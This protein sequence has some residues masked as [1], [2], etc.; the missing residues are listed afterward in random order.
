MRTDTAT[1]TLFQDD[2]D[3]KRWLAERGGPRDRESAELAAPA[4]FLIAARTLTRAD[5]LVAAWSALHDHSEFRRAGTGRHRVGGWDVDSSRLLFRQIVLRPLALR[6]LMAGLAGAAG[7]LLGLG[8]PQTLL[9]MCAVLSVRWRARYYVVLTVVAAAVALPTWWFPPL[10]VMTF[11]YVHAAADLLWNVTGTAWWARGPVF[12]FLPFADRLLLWTR[13]RWALFT[14]AVDLATSGQADAAEPFLARCERVPRHCRPVLGM[15]RAMHSLHRGDL[16]QALSRAGA[17]VEAARNSPAGVRGWCRAHLSHVL[18][19]GG[20]LDEAMAVRDEALLLLKGRRCRRY[21]RELLLARLSDDLPFEPVASSLHR[22]HRL[23]RVALRASDPNLLRQTEIWIVQLMLR[24]G[25]RAGAAWIL[26]GLLAGDDARTPWH[27]TPDQAANERLLRASVLVE[28]ESTRDSA[29]R[30]ALAALAIVDAGRRPLAAVAARLLLARAD[31]FDGRPGPALAQAAHALAAVHDARYLIPSARGRKQ[32]E[33]VQLNAYATV[34]RLA[35][36][37]GDA[38]LLAEVVETV[39][40]EVL[41]DR[42]D[43]TELEAHLALDAMTATAAPAGTPDGDGGTAVDTAAE[44]ADDGPSARGRTRSA[45]PGLDPVRRPPPVR[46]A[47]RRRLPTG[48]GRSGVIDLDVELCALGGRC[49][50]WSAAVVLDRYYWVV[51][52]PDGRWTHGSADIAQQS[53]AALAD[54]A[55]RQALPLP[56]PGEDAAAAAARADRGPLS[57]G[58]GPDGGKERA[59]LGSVAEAF[60]PAPLAAGLRATP[61]D[62]VPSLVVSLPAALAHLPVPALPLEPG[63]DRRV[64]DVARV[65]HVPAWS[66]VNQRL[67]R[68]P[69]QA[70]QPY[71]LRLAVMAPD[72]DPV[73]AARLKSPPFARRSLGGPLPKERLSQVLHLLDDDRHWLLYLAGHVTTEWNPT[74]GGLRLGPEGDGYGHLSIAEMLAAADSGPHANLFPVPE[75]VLAVGCGSLGLE[76]EPETGGARTPT[77]EW[78]GFGS[79]LMF[80]GADHVI[81]T[82]YPV[83]PVGQLNDIAHSL[84]ERLVAGDSPADALRDVQLAEL[85]RWRGTGEGR[86]F[87]WQ[88]FVYAGV[89]I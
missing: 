47:G 59:L 61:P 28:D 2:D 40:G 71:D 29:R 52:D 62:E 80:A 36:R 53:P 13:G 32:W 42:I 34:L 30:D 84:A 10:A 83:Y 46:V 7:S 65:L 35:E 48:A 41:P 51:R 5:A 79:A 87:L 11:W 70:G 26:P 72:G 88:A 78:L 50:Y 23:R 57:R 21:A 19:A 25:N 6:L 69:P 33:R 22:I 81:C 67:T 39:R 14:T 64:V 75:R 12:A 1:E 89:G 17:A 63:T 3:A 82:L 31:E 60:L 58:A 16:S 27:L 24:V 44:A 4:D 38:V 45:L 74:R 54:Q 9:T 66:V 68:R 49:W 43:R 76:H 8:A 15:A 56:L 20:R 55:L 73:A 77:S 85:N 86:P 37:S 18:L